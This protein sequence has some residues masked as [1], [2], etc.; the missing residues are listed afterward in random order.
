M[1]PDDPNRDD[2]FF[3]SWVTTEAVTKLEDRLLLVLNHDL[4]SPLTLAAGQ[5]PQI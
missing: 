4:H 3:E 2:D 5:K 1:Q